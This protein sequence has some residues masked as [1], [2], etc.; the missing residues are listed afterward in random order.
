MHGIRIKKFSM[1][2]IKETVSLSG[3]LLLGGIETHGIKMCSARFNAIM[4]CGFFTGNVP[5]LSPTAEGYSS[6]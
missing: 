6:L 5:D 3:S 4:E 2:E 1:E